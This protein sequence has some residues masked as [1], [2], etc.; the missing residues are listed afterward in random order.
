M[1]KIYELPFTCI[2]FWQ[3]YLCKTKYLLA[4]NKQLFKLL[5]SNIYGEGY[6]YNLHDYL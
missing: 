3:E 1:F 2:Y 5:M 6:V 4:T